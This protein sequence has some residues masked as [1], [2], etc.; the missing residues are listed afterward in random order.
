ME[1]ILDLIKFSVSGGFI[2]FCGVLI[3]TSVILGLIAQIVIYITKYLFKALF[4]R[5]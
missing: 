3:M 5:K 1:E 4:Q 2:K